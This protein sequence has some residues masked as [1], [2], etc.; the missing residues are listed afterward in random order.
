MEIFNRK[1][2]FLD[3]LKVFAAAVSPSG[4]TGSKVPRETKKVSSGESD[5][6]GEGDEVTFLSR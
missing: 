5:V 3:V 4:P 1:R 2:F 6:T